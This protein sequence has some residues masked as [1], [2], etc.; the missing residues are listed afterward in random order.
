[1]GIT[2]YLKKHKRIF[3][4]RVNIE[5]LKPKYISDISNFESYP[6]Y[7]S[8]GTHFIYTTIPQ[9][10]VTRNVPVSR[11]TTRPRLLYDLSSL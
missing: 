3:F 11:P 5:I 8:H 10:F 7:S 2:L 9:T 6:S 1:M 4:I